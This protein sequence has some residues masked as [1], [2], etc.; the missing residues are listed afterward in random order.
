MR[1]YILLQPN[2]SNATTNQLNGALYP[3]QMQLPAEVARH[4]SWSRHSWGGR[5]DR[6]G[7]LFQVCFINFQKEKVCFIFAD[8]IRDWFCFVSW[9][10]RS[11]TLHHGLPIGSLPAPSPSSPSPTRKSN[12]LHNLATT[13]VEIDELARIPSSSSSNESNLFLVGEGTVMEEEELQLQQPEGENPSRPLPPGVRALL[14]SSSSSSSDPFERR[15]AMNLAR[16]Y[17][18]VPPPPAPAR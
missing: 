17:L 5:H 3:L 18:P 9:S 11:R 16:S 12:P 6:A 10:A 4:A 8:R 15:C 7:F 14:E 1:A 2:T 13:R